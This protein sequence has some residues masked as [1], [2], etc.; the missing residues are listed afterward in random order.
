MTNLLSYGFTAILRRIDFLQAMKRHGGYLRLSYNRVR[1]Q[2]RR[3]F[4]NSVLERSMLCYSD[5]LCMILRTK[6]QLS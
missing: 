5:D 4:A 3:G 6:M 2:G 1:I